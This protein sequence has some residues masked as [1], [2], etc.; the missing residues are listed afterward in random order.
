[1][2]RLLA[3]IPAFC[4]IFPVLAAADSPPEMMNGMPAPTPGAPVAINKPAPAPPIPEDYFARY[5]KIL[6]PN[7]QPPYPFKLTMPAPGFGEIKIPNAGELMM[8]EKLERL[9]MLSDAEIRDQLEKWPAYSKMSLGDQ[10]AMLTRIQQFRDRRSK[11][12]AMKAHQLGLLTLN[13]QQQVKFEQEYWDKKL[14]MDH[15]LAQQF[16]PI[17]KARDQKLNE[18]LYR[19]FSSP[20]PLAVPT[21]PAPVLPPPAGPTV[22]VPPPPAAAAH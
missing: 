13:P 7:D 15:Q 2:A 16:E 11:V 10:G 4:G 9:A 6:A 8:R 17:Y 22:N 19:E 21:K 1:M 20:G 12:A 3:L 14:Q 5:G 18:D